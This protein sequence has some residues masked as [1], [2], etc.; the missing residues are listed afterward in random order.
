MATLDSL[1]IDSILAKVIWASKS[2]ALDCNLCEED[3]SGQKYRSLCCAYHV[4]D[5]CFTC[6]FSVFLRRTAVYINIPHASH[7]DTHMHHIYNTYNTYM[8]HIYIEIIHSRIPMRYILRCVHHIAT[9][10]HH[11]IYRRYS[12]WA[13]EW[14]TFRHER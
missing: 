13:S 11:K 14:M 7:S 9:S 1:R 4:Y 5:N 6:V 12:V 2:W 3:N 8:H 10:Q